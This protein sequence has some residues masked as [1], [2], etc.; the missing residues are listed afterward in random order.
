MA[1]VD[2][3]DASDGIRYQGPKRPG[4][5]KMENGVYVCMVIGQPIIR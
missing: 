3:G 1:A 2:L 4:T 5:A